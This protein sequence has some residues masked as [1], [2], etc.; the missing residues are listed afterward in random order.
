ML[1]YLRVIG[2]L[3]FASTLP[4]HDKFGP[5]SLKFVLLGCGTSQ[6]GYKLYDLDNKKIF[7]SIDV[8]FHEAIF[9]FKEC[10][11]I[12]SDPFIQV[13]HSVPMIAHVQHFSFDHSVVQVPTII[14]PLHSPMVEEPD[15][16]ALPF[17]IA[18]LI[19]LQ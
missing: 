4:R 10:K 19:I 17:S 18:P 11:A 12:S 3:C 16:T 13:Q 14:D 8:V 2:C 1:D 15:L 6:K 5:R 9:P 7:I